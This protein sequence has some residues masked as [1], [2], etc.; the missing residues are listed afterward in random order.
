MVQ[1]ERS[2]AGHFSGTLQ[3]APGVVAAEVGASHSHH[4]SVSHSSARRAVL[5]QLHR[6]SFQSTAEPGC[7]Q[8]FCFQTF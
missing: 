3:V 2:K 7:T 4:H 5:E 1:G 8:S 6:V